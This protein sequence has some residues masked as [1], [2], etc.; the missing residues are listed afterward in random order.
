M[1][2]SSKKSD[3]KSVGKGSDNDPV[4]NDHQVVMNWLGR[5]TSGELSAEPPVPAKREYQELVQKI[6]ALVEAQR[7]DMR[8]FLIG[9]NRS[10]YESTEIS[11]T[12][13]TIVRGNERVSVCVDEMNK[14][15]ES[16]ANDIVGLAG[17]AHETS[18]QTK[19]GQEAMALADRS[20]ATVSDETANAERG[21]QTMNAS[22][23]KLHDS[24]GHINELVASVKGIADQT[25]L[26]S[27]NA[28]IEAARAGEHGRGFAVV[29]EEVRKLAEQSK[30]SVQ[31]IN[32]QLTAIS[33]AADHITGEFANMDQAFKNNAGAVNEAGLHTRKLATVFEGIG[34]AISTLAP[35]AQEQSA[36]FEEMT[37]NLRT[38]L[39][40]VHKQ[41]QSTH[42]CNRFVYEALQTNNKMRT[43][44][45]EK[46]LDISSREII[47][48]AKTDH[49]LWRAR[50]NQM[51]WGNL[52]LDSGSVR[53][54]T[55]CRLGKWCSGQGHE[56]FGK[57]PL[58]HH[59]EQCHAEFHR[60]CAEAID[61]YASKDSKRANELADSVREI[62][63][64]VQG[65]LDELGKSV[66]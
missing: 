17:T 29:A 24:T 6:S 10:V 50:I 3:K 56:M 16:L 55:A 2:F 58:F 33:D 60:A 46:N 27:L 63:Q 19:N 15:V 11:D 41:N 7:A 20:I 49:L 18:V 32:D 45:A 44:L 53:D 28:S 9:L 4:Q 14:V 66:E 23:T 34:E 39:E 51:L 40:D 65:C 35:M 38:T 31:K 47:D 61:A 54:H 48:L 62:S 42:E 12:L 1:F 26:L 57:H 30:H 21:L 25:N 5:L 64:E 13:N 43:E 36:A 8:Q 22:V 52:S 37:A 59:L